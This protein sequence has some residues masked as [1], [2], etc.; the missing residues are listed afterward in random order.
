[1]GI[2]ERKQRQKTEVR[3][4]ILQAAWELVQK[5]GWQSLSI[6]KIADAIEYSVPVIYDHFENKND[7]LLEFVKEGFQGLLDALRA[8]Q[9]QHTEPEAQITA[10]AYAYWDYALA[11]KAHY[12]LMFGVGM[13]TCEAFQ[14]V[15]PLCEIGQLVEAAIRGVAAGNPH[16]V[17]IVIKFQALWS[18]LHGI[19]A[20]SIMDHMFAPYG[21]NGDQVFA[22]IVQNF[23]RGLKE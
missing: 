13:N 10:M 22:D 15:A 4:A 17:D 2:A 16:P 11:N 21:H 23:I 8:V 20:A 19:S 6:R 1:M 18:I 3:A 7:I 12:R 14:K 5:D 9:Q